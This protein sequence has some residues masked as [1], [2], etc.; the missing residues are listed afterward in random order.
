MYVWELVCCHNTQL[1]DGSSKVHLQF[2]AGCCSL[3]GAL[4]ALGLQQEHLCR[5]WKGACSHWLVVYRAHCSSMGHCM[6]AEK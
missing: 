1:L 3:L 6:R 4:A 2:A 5:P